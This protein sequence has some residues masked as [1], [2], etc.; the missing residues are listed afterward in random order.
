MKRHAIRTAN[1][2]AVAM[3]VGSGAV[4]A[5]EDRYFEL[6]AGYEFSSGKYGTTSTTDIVTIPVAAYYE[7]GP[8][9]L[10]L[11][12]PYIRVT[13]DGSVLASGGGRGRHA[14]TTSTTTTITTN[15]GLGDVVALVAYN[16]YAADEIDA[17]IDLT[18]RVKFG[19]ANK[20]LGTGMNDY[21]VQ[22]FGYRAFGNFT[23]SL[24][25]G[26]EVL[27]SSTQVPLD[28]VYYGSAAGDYRFSE[29]GNG[30]VE[31]RYVQKAS[32]T[33]AEQRELVLYINYGIGQDTYLRGYLLK[34]FANGSPDS[35]MGLSLSAMY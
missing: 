17:G 8:W 28:S 14:T 24:V 31:Y 33:A 29:M 21:A 7:T 10:K 3:A 16:V 1:L 23:P 25:L 12:V 34:G 4:Y 35:G 32:L 27:G 30:G 22:M 26:Y 15:A 13:G 6:S 19:T 11:T 5:E 18:G 20:T 9:S 2:L